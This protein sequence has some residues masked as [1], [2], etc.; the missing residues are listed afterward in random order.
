MSPGGVRD[1]VLA[2]RNSL[3]LI[4][5]SCGLAHDLF[6]P[7][8]DGS[9]P[10]SREAFAC[11][12][13]EWEDDDYD[14]RSPRYVVDA[15]PEEVQSRSRALLDKQ[16]FKLQVAA[17]RRRERAGGLD[18]SI[19]AHYEAVLAEMQGEA[20]RLSGD[21]A[22]PIDRIAQLSGAEPL[23][24]AAKG[25][26]C[27]SPTGAGRREPPTEAGARSNGMARWRPPPLSWQIVHGERTA[28]TD[29]SLGK[30]SPQPSLRSVTSMAST[31]AG[32]DEEAGSIEVDLMARAEKKSRCLPGR[33]KS[34]WPGEEE[35]EEEEEEEQVMQP[36]RSAQ[37][38]VGWQGGL[39]L[40]APFVES[41]LGCE[42]L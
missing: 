18:G 10:L 26:V 37:V 9:A 22:A 8:E 2:D 23:E 38:S 31:S 17:Q 25:M 20:R 21:G 29:T 5:R 14:P 4:W 19:A 24:D 11:H 15:A 34:R 28:S 35:H 3:G 33:P 12:D 30:L 39:F 40:G 6:A 27:E 32:L 16:M 7:D 36:L 41:T 1:E 42:P 13:D